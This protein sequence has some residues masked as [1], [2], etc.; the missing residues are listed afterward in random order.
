[1]P[2]APSI[3]AESSER[4]FSDPKGINPQ[5]MTHTFETGAEGRAHL[6]AGTHPRRTPY[7]VQA[8]GALRR[9]M[10]AAAYTH[11]GC[12]LHTLFD[13]AFDFV[14]Q[15]MLRL[16]VS[17]VRWDVG[18]HRTNVPAPAMVHGQARRHTWGS[19]GQKVAYRMALPVPNEWGRHFAKNATCTRSCLS[20]S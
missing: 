7:D 5:F 15:L 11:H 2:F 1:M 10:K 3:R 17:P 20:K 6:A 9:Q 4:Y 16:I 18:H 8:L 19:T 13:E 14:C 12:D